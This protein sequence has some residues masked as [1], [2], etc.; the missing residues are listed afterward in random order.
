MQAGTWLLR[1][2]WLGTYVQTQHDDFADVTGQGAIPII[3]MPLNYGL[4]ANLTWQPRLDAFML[5]KEMTL[6]AE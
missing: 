3:H 4:S 6:A 5:L 1:L 2:G